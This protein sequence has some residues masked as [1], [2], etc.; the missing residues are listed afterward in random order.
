MV[1]ITMVPPVT[2]ILVILA[3][4][5]IMVMVAMVAKVPPVNVFVVTADGDPS[6]SSR[7]QVHGHTRRQGRRIKQNDWRAPHLEKRLRYPQ[8]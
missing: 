4:V 5:V 6:V 3:I 1:V 2:A 8:A 7:S